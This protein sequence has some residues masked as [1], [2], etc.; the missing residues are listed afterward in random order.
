MFGNERPENP[1]GNADEHTQDTVPARR[2][3]PPQLRKEYVP[4]NP[5][6]GVDMKMVFDLISKMNE[7]NQKNLMSAIAELKKP[8]PREQEKLDKEEAKVKAQQQARLK[9]AMAEEQR[10]KNN[11]LGCRHATVHP[12]TGVVKHAWRAQVHTPLGEKPYF[13]PTC[14][15]CWTQA[16]KILATPDMLTQGV[17]LDQYTTIDYDVLKKWSE[18][19]S[20]AQV[21]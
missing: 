18:Q 21:A 10:K 3:R 5:N 14:Q 9:L 6:V 11:I 2:G 17:N 12:G 16:P 4:E 20:A 8:T 1:T 7:D 19:S 15:I 13:V